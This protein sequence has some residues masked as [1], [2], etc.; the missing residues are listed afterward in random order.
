MDHWAKE[1]PR[2]PMRIDMALCAAFTRSYHRTTIRDL[3]PLSFFN[4]PCPFVP[5][6]VYLDPRQAPN[7]AWKPTLTECAI[8]SHDGMFPVRIADVPS[9]RPRMVADSG[10]IL[11]YDSC[12]Y[13][14]LECTGL[15]SYRVEVLRSKY[16]YHYQ[17]SGR[18]ETHCDTNILPCSWASS[19][20]AWEPY[21]D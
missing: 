16:A 5:I 17:S 7:W 8:L 18:L 2:W 1:S 4:S 12:L 10:E 9:C 3:R 19:V 21:G 14:G 13:Q 11:A 15:F 20:P 6:F